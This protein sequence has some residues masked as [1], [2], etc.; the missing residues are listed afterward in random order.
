MDINWT[1][2][3]DHFSMRTIIESLP[4]IPETNKML[5]QL[6]LNL[7][8]NAKE[9]KI[10]AIP[11]FFYMFLG[12]WVSQFYHPYTGH[13]SGIWTLVCQ[14]EK[15]NWGETLGRM[16]RLVTVPLSLCWWK[17]NKEVVRDAR[18]YT[19]SLKTE[20]LVFMLVRITIYSFFVHSCLFLKFWLSSLKL[21]GFIIHW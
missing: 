11:V 8:K 13:C 17:L 14:K 18:I 20:L 12:L 3:G 9:D 21:Y 1:Y 2:C 4:Y 5:C 16:P 15:G 19:L 6:Y 7:K 10:I